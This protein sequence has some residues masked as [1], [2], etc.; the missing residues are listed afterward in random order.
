MKKSNITKSKKKKEIP[1][2]KKVEAFLIMLF[3]LILPW[4][5]R[6]KVVKLDEIS[7]QY[8]QNS[9]GY[10]VDLFL[11][12][13]AVLIIVIAVI[14]ILMI[15]GDNIFPDYIIKDTPIRGFWYVF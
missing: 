6:L 7:A 1:D 2:Y 10:M 3:M 15:I 12:Y 13:K 8:F 14:I 4:I 9:N 11:Y 5:T